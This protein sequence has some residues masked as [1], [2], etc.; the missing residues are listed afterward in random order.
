MLLE[1]ELSRHCD[2]LATVRI[3]AVVGSDLKGAASMATPSAPT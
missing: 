2:W 3:V 1:F